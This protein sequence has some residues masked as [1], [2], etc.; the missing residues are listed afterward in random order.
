MPCRQASPVDAECVPPQE[1]LAAARA[2][3]LGIPNFKTLLSLRFL[4]GIWALFLGVF[5]E[6][7]CAW[8]AGLLLLAAALTQTAA[9][10][11]P[12]LWYQYR[13]S[14]LAVDALTGALCVWGLAG[15]TLIRAVFVWALPFVVVQL[16]LM[17]LV[18]P[19][20]RMHPVCYPSFKRGGRDVAEP[21]PGAARAWRWRRASLAVTWSLA[22]SVFSLVV[23]MTG[24]RLMIYPGTLFKVRM[25]TEFPAE[26]G[27]DIETVAFKT[28]D[29]KQLSAFFMK[30]GAE[31]ELRIAQA[32]PAQPRLTM[33]IFYGNTGNM[34]HQMDLIV[35]MLQKAYPN[36]Q[37]FIFSYRGYVTSDGRPH[38]A[39]LRND[40]DAAIRYLR[41]RQE[42]DFARLVGYGH[43]IG[44]A[45]V[46]DVL[47]RHPGI[48]KG[49][50]LSN[51]F[52]SME[53]MADTWRVPYLKPFISEPWD[54]RA[55][56]A[57][58]AANGSLPPMLF[59]SSRNDRLIPA[60]HMDRL[61]EIAQTAPT[62]PAHMWVALESGTHNQWNDDEL[63]IRSWRQF[64]TNIA[65]TRA[66]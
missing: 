49:V 40:M 25:P 16:L 54:S 39:G 6:E 50:I 18:W 55:A 3:H 27:L 44:G 59:M 57:K 42:V 31:L 5:Y 24:Q 51:T 52:L 10:I 13:N 2:Y 29:N 1:A 23:A 15:P 11:R 60:Y 35:P 21:G 65:H 14:L 20:H 47:G 38:I 62:A 8:S 33:W 37:F 28:A 63:L 43:S 22:F 19:S 53:A 48:L 61:Y 32:A 46:S 58:A 34:V 9:R 7:V 36:L 66:R 64:F 30:P 17:L 41:R 26:L 45:L 56:L 12:A 4:T